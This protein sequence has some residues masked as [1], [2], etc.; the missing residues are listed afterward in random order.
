MLRP[1]ERAKTFPIRVV[2]LQFFEE[3]TNFKLQE[4]NWLK[5]LSIF[6]LRLKTDQL[7]KFRSI[8]A[9]SKTIKVS[10]AL[11]CPSVQ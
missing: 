1:G 3:L 5:L 7:E 10:Y 2:Q 6:G 9:L 11:L 8:S 4:L